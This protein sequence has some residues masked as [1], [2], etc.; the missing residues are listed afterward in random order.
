[1]E[2]YR[3]AKAR[4]FA[5][6]DDAAVAVVNRDDPAHQDVIRGCPARIVGYSLQGETEITARISR[7]TI[8]GT[9]YRMRIDGADLVLENA[10]IGR[11]NVYNALAAA[12]LARALGA[13]ARAIEAGLNS[14]RNIPGRLQRVPCMQGVDVLVDYAHTDDA[15]RNVLSVLRP[16]TQRRLIVVFGCGGDR[17]KLKRPRMAKAVAEFADAIV[18]TSDNPRTEDPQA[19]ITDILAGFEADARRKV[20]VEADRKRAI[21]AAL[22]GASGGDVVLI[23]GKGH[24]DCQIVGG[25]RLHF[26]DVE[27]A[28]AAGAELERSQTETHAR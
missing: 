9:L 23:A 26:D 16:L 6:L 14:V 17:D 12:G 15:L 2:R 27:V 4:L 5:G 28:I 1:M 19:I 20:L 10:L 13:D 24:E 11:H 7:D 3:D 18:V 8:R 22:G 21:H 25:Q